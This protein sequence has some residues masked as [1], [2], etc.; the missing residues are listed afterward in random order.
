VKAIAPSI[1][2]AALA[3][4]CTPACSSAQDG[5]E[6]SEAAV[7]VASIDDYEFQRDAQG[8]FVTAGLERIDAM[9]VALTSTALTNRDKLP[10]DELL[11]GA[12]P[13][14][15]SDNRNRYQKDSPVTNP[16]AATGHLVT[17]R[18]FLAKMHKGWADQFA[19]LGFEPCSV[20]IPV[21]GK[22]VIPCTLQKLGNNADP[23]HGPRVLDVALPDW[24]TLSIDKPRG[25]PNGRWLDE[26]VNDTVLA[27]GFLKMGGRC[28]G[29]KSE[30][31]KKKDGV[32]MCNVETF[33]NIKL[34]P[35]KND[36]EFG[37]TFPYLARPWFYDGDKGKP[38]WPTQRDKPKSKP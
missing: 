11:I 38:Y 1:V 18:H 13:E 19:A 23:E 31:A 16:V 12:G 30:L 6:S 15:G 37:A 2:L 10:D 21:V 8:H 27:M 25:F 24:V 5:I 36:K 20:D 35:P 22:G 9:G 3:L 14:G 26:Q 32:P 34:N 29:D 17:F 7:G 4:A 28:P 33:K